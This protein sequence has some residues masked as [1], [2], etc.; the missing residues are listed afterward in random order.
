MKK[1]MCLLC[2]L[3][4]LI[5]MCSSARATDSFQL[6]ELTDEECISFLENYGVNIPGHESGNMPWIPFARAVIKMVGGEP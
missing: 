2:M 1:V 3:V 6:S 4:V 5:A